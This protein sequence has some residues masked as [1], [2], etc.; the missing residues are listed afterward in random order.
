M[1]DPGLLTLVRQFLITAMAHSCQMVISTDGGA[2]TCSA[3]GA[4]V[5][6]LH[7]EATVATAGGPVHGEDRTPFTAELEAL[8]QVLRAICLVCKD[9][10]E[11][12]AIFTAL[13]IYVLIDCTSAIDFLMRQS[14]PNDRPAFWSSLH[15]DR[16]VIHDFGIDISFDWVPSHGKI[17]EGWSPPQGISETCARRMNA[18]A[19][20]V[21]SLFLHAAI[22]GAGLGPW[23]LAVSAAKNW[24]KAVLAYARSLANDFQQHCEVQLGVNSR[25]A[26]LTQ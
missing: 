11:N 3:W 2:D 24:S 13:R 10:S 7:E 25:A 19:D 1:L 5:C 9:M 26:G 22:A 8:R 21:A 17:S 23:R 4:A 18:A 12:G 14:P 15:N 6:C 20:E 16:Q